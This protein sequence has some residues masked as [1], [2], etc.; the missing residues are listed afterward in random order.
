MERKVAR[1]D[2]LKG[3]ALGAA[4]AGLA[5]R[6]TSASAP[7]SDQVVLALLGAGRQGMG[8][9]RAFSEQPDARVVAVC[10][11]Y[12]PH[13]DKAQQGAA[14]AEAYTDFR[15]VLDRPDVQAVVVATPDHWHPLMTVMACQAGKDVYVEKPT[16]VVVE[17]GRRM[18][19]AARKHSRVVQVGT[20]QRSGAHFRHA[21]ELVRGG[22][23]GKVTL[24]R[25]WNV[26]N[27]HPDG[28]GNPPDSAPPPELDWD[29]WL[30]PAPRVPFNPNRFGVHP[31]RWSTFRWFWDYA[32]GM[33]TDWGVHLLDVVQWAMDVDA[34][35]AV[36]ASGGKLA[37]TDNRETPDTLV[38]SFEYP[39]FLA[40]YENRACNGRPLADHGYGIEF[41]GTEGTLFVDREGFE[42]F[43]E[44]RSEGARRK[45]RAEAVRE[46]ASN[47]QLG[48]HLR[49]FLDCVKSRERPVSDIEIGHRS[50]TACLLGNV[51]YR[52]G[53][54]V[55]W[56]RSR[57]EIVGDPPAAAYLRREYR[58]PW[59]LQV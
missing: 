35:S 14:G 4:G 37:L 52:A 49:N 54:R 23:L 10:D 3:T 8:L 5:A 24:V 29:L 34:P 43:P 30:G 2:F 12:G 45:P 47:P 38:V 15:R 58:S 27:S 51:A 17:E 50:T 1:R 20:Q 26:G 39:G 11:V 59:K 42:V 56:D 25:T 57:E 6:R 22:R 36:S 16:S 18:V 9:L 40:L 13:R 7:P 33:M 55:R 41:H 44:W 28:I 21:V 53:R 19:E 32:G 31:D 46:A 48:T